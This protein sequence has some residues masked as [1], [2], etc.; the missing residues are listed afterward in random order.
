[1]F[2]RIVRENNVVAKGTYIDLGCGSGYNACIFSKYFSEIFCLDILRQNL[3]N[4]RKI[5][6]D[7]NVLA[8]FIIGDAQKLPFKEKSFD[9]VSAFSLIEHLP[10]QQGFMKEL[11]RIL[12]EKG[13]LLMQF[14]DGDFMIE[15]HT[16]ILFPQIIPQKFKEWYVKKFLGWKS[17]S[18]WNLTRRKALI[19][20]KSF[21]ENIYVEKMNYAEKVLPTITRP[22]YK[23]FDR[24][25]FFY[26]CPLS[27]FF[28][29]IKRSN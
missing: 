20:C 2:L 8:Y 3:I 28:I 7:N 14:P 5:F 9:V 19:L 10:E 22:L 15:L 12:K 18:V 1:M 23:L 13:M 26:L 27:Y 16:C 21:F 29:C 17:Y 24:F 4:T 6:K 25:G 11:N